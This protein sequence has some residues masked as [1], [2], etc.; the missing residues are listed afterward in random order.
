[1]STEGSVEFGGGMSL[2]HKEVK[3]FSKKSAAVRTEL[4]MAG[5]PV[6]IRAVQGSGGQEMQMG[7]VSD[8]DPANVAMMLDYLAPCGCSACPS[9]GSLEKSS[10]K[11]K[12][13]VN[14]RRWWNSPVTAFKRPTFR[15]SDGLLIQQRRPALDGSNVTE[16]LGQYIPFGELDFNFP[17]PAPPTLRGKP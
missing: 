3:R 7:T 6:M 15:A 4:S 12:W 1:M 2:Q 5:Q 10:V 8:M 14:C 17:P 9:L 11:K 13:P 16:T